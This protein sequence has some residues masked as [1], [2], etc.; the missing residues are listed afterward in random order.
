MRQLEHDETSRPRLKLPLTVAC[1]DWHGPQ[2]VGGLFRLADAYGVERLLLGGRTPAPPNRKIGSTARSTQQWIPFT[3]AADLVDALR[4]YREQGYTLVGL[5]ITDRS[6]PIQQFDF[7][8]LERVVLVAGSE[9]AG[10]QPGVLQMLDAA[11][12]IPMYGRNSSMNVT[13]ALAIA[14]YEVS[15]QRA[16]S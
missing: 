16:G 11:V 8:S 3:V 6:V 10:I 9:N 15:R 2:N 14:L 1:D 4:D 5:E 12:H 13:A 7:R